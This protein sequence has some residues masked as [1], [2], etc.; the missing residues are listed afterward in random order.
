MQR[1]LIH[2]VLAGADRIAA[3]GDTLSKIGTYSLALVAKA[4]NIPFVVAAPMSTIDFGVDR[5]EGMAISEHS[6]EEIY[7]LG[8]RVTAPKQ[9]EFYNPASDITPAHLITAIVTEQGSFTPDQIGT[10]RAI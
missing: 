2:G 8:E 9:A 3:N 10:L 4:H 1:G 7:Q 6:P 5:G